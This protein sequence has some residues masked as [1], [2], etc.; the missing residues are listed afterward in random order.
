MCTGGLS[1]V[2]WAGR[3]VVVEGLLWAFLVKSK[4]LFRTTNEFPATVLVRVQYCTFGVDLCHMKIAR[5]R[6]YANQ[7]KNF[8]CQKKC[9]ALMQGLVSSDC[10]ALVFVWFHSESKCR[11]LA[12]P[13]RTLKSLCLRWLLI[14]DYHPGWYV[15]RQR[16]LRRSLGPTVDTKRCSSHDSSW[17]VICQLS[18]LLGKLD[19]GSIQRSRSAANV[20]LT[21]PEVDLL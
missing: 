17:T 19:D 7:K 6:T 18:N 20:G 9:I 1:E 3:F 4:G 16:Q 2:S 12:S 10:L 11:W 15:T 21:L 5:G 14:Q 13:L 8:P